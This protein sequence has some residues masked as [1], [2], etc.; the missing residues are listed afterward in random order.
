MLR[1]LLEVSKRKSIRLWLFGHSLGAGAAAIAAMELNDKDFISVKAVG[2]GCPP[3]LSAQLAQTAKDFIT[4]VVADA[5]VV[6]RMSGATIAN[7]MLDIMS[8]DWTD[9][10]LVDLEDMLR[11]L[12]TNPPFDILP[13]GAL[14]TVLSWTKQYF[15]TDLKPVFGNVTKER[16]EPVLVPPGT[17]IHAFR[18]GV[19]YTGTYTNCSLFTEIDIA[20]TLVDDHFLEV[21]YHRAFLSLIR[22]ALGNFKIDFQ[23][24]VSAVPV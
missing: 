14:D 5:D 8:F 6:P 19:S 9:R 21:G 12:S 7:V 10:A 23:H 2:F 17:C 1:H 24:D 4:T 18:D 3:V 20:R 15:E 16:F 11:M 22:D 13:Q